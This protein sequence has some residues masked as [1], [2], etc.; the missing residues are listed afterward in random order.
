[1]ADARASTGERASSRCLWNVYNYEHWAAPAPACLLAMCVRRQARRGKASKWLDCECCRH[2]SVLCCAG[3]IS[4]PSPPPSY[5]LRSLAGQILIGLT[6]PVH[7]GV[8]CCDH[9]CHGLRGDTWHTHV[10][11]WSVSWRACRTSV[12]RSD[13]FTVGLCT[14]T[15]RWSTSLQ[16]SHPQ[17]LDGIM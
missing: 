12:S 8:V 3:A 11:S 13:V 6:L 1:M 9:C 10:I 5:Q 16:P 17:V 2:R 7:A 4:L 15:A 14:C